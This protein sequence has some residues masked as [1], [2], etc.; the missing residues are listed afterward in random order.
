MADLE[1]ILKLID[2]GYT[3][4]EIQNLMK[5][6]EAVKEEPQ[7]EE[8]PKEEPENKDSLTKIDEAIAKLDRLGEAIIKLNINGSNQPTQENYEDMLAKIID[9]NYGKE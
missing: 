7:K 9:P 6:A 3:R 8:P 4:E 5:P 1:Q 2:A